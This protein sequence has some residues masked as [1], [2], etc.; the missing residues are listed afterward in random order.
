MCVCVCVYVCVCMWIVYSLECMLLVLNFITI[1]VLSLILRSRI[2]IHEYAC[3]NLSLY[4]LS[5]KQI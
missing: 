3:T 5:Y 1:R 4:C 2:T